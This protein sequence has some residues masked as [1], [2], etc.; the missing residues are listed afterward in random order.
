M[1]FSGS[2]SHAVDFGALMKLPIVTPVVLLLEKALQ[3]VTSHLTGHRSF[4]TASTHRLTFFLLTR[5]LTTSHH[6]LCFILLQLVS[7]GTQSDPCAA[8]ITTS[9]LEYHQ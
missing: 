8:S 2:G 5:C 3:W 1:E 4:L 9:T 6:L 7:L